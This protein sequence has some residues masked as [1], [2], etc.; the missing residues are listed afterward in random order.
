[1]RGNMKAERAR[2]GLSAREV[3][4]LIGVSVNQISR[5]E[6][7]EQEPSASNII[8]LSRLYECTPEYLMGI[9]DD[10]NGRAIPQL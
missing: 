2:R 7:G 6:T 8:N 9:T 4:E 10:K 1:M 3:S 5:W